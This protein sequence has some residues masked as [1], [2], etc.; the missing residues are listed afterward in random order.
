MLLDIVIRR[1]ELWACIRTLTVRAER[2]GEKKKEE[3]N[4][5]EE[6]EEE[7]YTRIYTCRRSIRFEEVL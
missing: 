4:D 5:D 6:E 2:E 1:N 7:A 3:V